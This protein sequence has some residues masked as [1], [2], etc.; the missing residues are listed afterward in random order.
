LPTSLRNSLALLILAAGLGTTTA[1]SGKTAP[2]LP[3]AFQGVE[4]DAAYQPIVNRMKNDGER[5]WVLHLNELSIA[6]LRRGDR[7]TAKRA[8]DE[9]ILLI[10][11][12]F[13]TSEASA[14]A[15]SLFF[16]EDAKLYK[17]DPYERSMTF[18]YRG[19]LYMQDGD[20]SNGASAMRAAIFQDQF[21]EE[22]QFR[23]DWSTFDYLIAV[24]EVRLGER[25]MAAES[26]ERARRNYE[27]MAE[28]YDALRRGFFP[29]MPERLTPPTPADNLLVV[30]TVGPAPRKVQ[31]G[32]YGELLAV[33]RGA[34]ASSPWGRVRVGDQGEW[35]EAV[36][37]DSVFFQ[38]A[39]RGGRY[40][41]S[42]AGR[43]VLFKDS[44]Q[45]ASFAA[46][47]AGI[48]VLLTA[49]QDNVGALGLALLGAGFALDLFAASIQT[50]ADIRTWRTLPDSIGV[51]LGEVSAG[52][53]TVTIAMAGSPT[54]SSTVVIPPPGA[55]LR[56]LLALP[57]SRQAVVA[58]DADAIRMELDT[59][60]A[61]IRA[62]RAATAH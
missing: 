42:I 62:A 53:H 49:N 58:N 18:F 55:G 36:M 29:V 24:C 15:R 17:G 59:L 41:D 19:V 40:F 1:C 52:E 30:Y 22:D 26:F 21:A 13:G 33:E 38:A 23:C 5:N 6:A 32:R 14:R 9:A 48:A 54:T 31:V 46:T 45:I 3:P 7:E 20:W 25:R 11:D 61:E 60:L 57:G 34:P 44:A 4:V 56:V 37:T 16:N 8:L 47:V 35:M 27:A 2:G 28:S 12:V 10:N 50:K 43:K 39:T 51:Y